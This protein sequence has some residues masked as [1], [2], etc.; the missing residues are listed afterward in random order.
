MKVKIKK[1]SDSLYWYNK[2]IGEEFD[3]HRF[4]ERFVWVREPNEY[5]CLNF[6]EVCDLEQFEVKE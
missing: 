6:I 5:Q 2:H 4:G 1:C 3:V